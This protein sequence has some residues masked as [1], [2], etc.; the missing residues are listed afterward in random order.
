[1]REYIPREEREFVEQIVQAAGNYVTASEDLRPRV[2]EAAR[3]N[4]DG[5]RAL[6]LAGCAALAVSALFIIS[7][8][9][10]RSAERLRLQM[11]GPSG[12]AVLHD[13]SQRSHSDPMWQLVEYFS[14]SPR[15]KVTTEPGD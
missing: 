1:M 6:R 11:R 13:I 2:V 4:E 9:I 5:R 3:D 10:G 8:P 12:E 15:P 14:S 7:V